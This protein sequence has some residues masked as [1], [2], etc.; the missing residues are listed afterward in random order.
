MS[1]AV[2]SAVPNRAL[3][4]FLRQ[5]GKQGP[6]QRR[7][8]LG[9]A[10]RLAGLPPSAPPPQDRPDTDS[11][12][13]RYPNRPAQRQTSPP[14][15]T[16]S[17][18]ACHSPT[19]PP[20]CKYPMPPTHRDDHRSPSTLGE[21]ADY[22]NNAIEC[23]PKGNRPRQSRI[24]EESYRDRNTDPSMFPQKLTPPCSPRFCSAEI[25]GSQSHRGNGTLP[26]VQ[27]GAPN[28]AFASLERTAT[29]TRR[30]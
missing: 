6:A 9:N 13:S 7:P 22:S 4:P 24:R 2:P 12:P 21:G 18:N 8:G 14:I 5:H 16:H 1:I 28:R 30:L 26:H 20:H 10:S 11:K 19:S 17:R 25:S 29:T 23:S 27:A 15:Q 3:D